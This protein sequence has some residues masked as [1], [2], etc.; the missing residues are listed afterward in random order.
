MFFSFIAVSLAG[1]FY[2]VARPLTRIFHLGKQISHEQAARIIG[3][4]FTDVQDKLLNVLQLRKQADASSS[5]ELAFASIQQKTESIKLIPFK[6]AINLNQNRKYLRFALPPL[7]VLLALLLGAP[8]VIKDSTN[9]I[10]HN[11]KEFE[12]DA[13]FHFVLEQADNLSVEQYDDFLLH[14]QVEGMALPNEIFINVDNYQYRL[15]KEQNDRFTYRFKNVHADTRFNLFAGPVA[16]KPYTLAVLKK[17]NL[18]SFDVHLDYPAYTGRKD[19]SLANIGDLVVPTGTTVTWDFNTLN[20]DAVEMQFGDELP[21]EIDRKGNDLFSQSHRLLQD[22]RYVLNMSN[23]NLTDPESIEYTINVIPD[24]YPKISVE[25]FRDSLEA[26][27]VYFVGNAGDDYGISN[28]TFNYQITNEDQKQEDPV[29]FPLTLKHRTQFQYD[30]T[31]DIKDLSLKPGQQLSY[32][33]EVFDNDAIN[34]SK[35][36]R[37]GLMT[38]KKPTVDEYE[39]MEEQNS[40][41]IKQTLKNSLKESKKLQEEMRKLREKLLQEKDMEWQNKKELENI[42]KRQ[43]EL[44]ND[45]Q[46][47]QDLFQENLQNQEEYENPTEEMKEKQEKLNEFFEELMNEE[48]QEMME[49]MQEMMEELQKKDALEMLENF[50]LSEEELQK[51]LDR[52]MEMFKQMELEQEIQEQVQKL[53]KLAEEQEELSEKTKNA[54]QEQQQQEESEQ[55]EEE[56]R[57][58]EE[59]QQQSEGQEENQEENQEQQDQQPSDEQQ[60][61]SALQQEQQEIQEEFQ[62]IKEEME[63]IQEKNQ[64]LERPKNLDGTDEQMERIEQDMNNSQQQM[65]Q[66]QNQKASES[67]KSAAQRMRDMAQQMQQQMMQGQMQQMQADMGTLRQLLENLITLSFDQEDIIDQM[68]IT[69]VTTPRYVTLVQDQ[70]KIKDDFKVVEDTLQALSK[71]SHLFRRRS[72]RSNPTCEAPLTTLKSAKR[73]RPRTFSNAQ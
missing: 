33:F 59:E 39:Q 63:K 36:S 48:M 28:L 21:V 1:L 64:E 29:S 53:E 42:M 45:L 7:L 26:T 60:P 22:S 49:K 24:L 35:S 4:H 19:E 34:G 65:Q 13:P 15:K 38:F 32:Y 56:T 46:N 50:E 70:F 73:R 43:Q 72:P 3:L 57:Q 69:N 51:E 30:Y 27:L 37:T 12:R 44:Q 6:N 17:P 10:I 47:A 52:L 68:T 18:L 8:S 23:A 16:S 20:T 66:Q 14:V 67:Q 41:D 2:W 54:D 40:E 62:D 11:N 5:P 61:N 9:R 71:L 58:A 25:Q 31:F 55:T